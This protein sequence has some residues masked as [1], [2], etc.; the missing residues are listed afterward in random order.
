[1]RLVVEK[2]KGNTARMFLIN[3]FE[4]IEEE[5]GDWIWDWSLNSNTCSKEDC[6]EDVVFL[7]TEEYDEDDV[8]IV[9]EI[10]V[11]ALPKLIQYQEIV[12]MFGVE[13]AKKHGFESGI[14]NIPLDL[15]GSFYVTDKVSK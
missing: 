5:I 4:Y 13:Y 7:E 6:T 15:K 8:P 1:M 11:Y 12:Y 9:E 10:E 14:K 3:R 2:T